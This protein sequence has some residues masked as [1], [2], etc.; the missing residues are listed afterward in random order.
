[1]V[2]GLLFLLLSWLIGFFGA[3]KG[4][5]QENSYWQIA[6]AVMLSGLFVT[7]VN[8]WILQTFLPAWQ[9]R[10]FLILTDC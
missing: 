3:K 7:T 9:G 10:A 8:T 5:D 6:V 1:M 2:L 4:K